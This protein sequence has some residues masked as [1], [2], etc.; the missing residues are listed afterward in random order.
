MSVIHILDPQTANLIAAGEVVD[1][2]ASVVKELLENAIDSGADTITAEIKN[3]GCSLIRITDNGCGMSKEDAA[4]CVKRH[5]TSKLKNPDDLFR[6]ATLGFR[7]EALAAISSVSTFSII[8]KRKQDPIGTKFQVEGDE[9]L[10]YD[11][12]GCPDGTTVLVESL[13]KNQPAR[14]KFLKRDATEASAVLQ[15]VQRI[16]VSHPEISFTF[17]SNGETK[18]QTA[19]NGVLKAAI[20]S[21]YGRE[22]ASSLTPVNGQSEQGIRVSGFITRPDA[23]RANRSCQ[24][25]Y[26]NNRFVKSK[27]MLFALEDAY[28]SYM[29]SDRFPGCVLCLSIDCSRVD[30]NVHPAKLEV[31]F[32]DER[33]VYNAVY[34]AVKNALQGE[35]TPLVYESTAPF[36]NVER[37]VKQTEIKNQQIEFSIAIPKVPPTPPK[38][39][40]LTVSQP[41]LSELKERKEKGDLT[42][43]EVRELEDLLST[44]S[45]PIPRAPFGSSL[46]SEKSF[47]PVC[48]DQAPSAPL[49]SLTFPSKNAENAD[50]YPHNL[51]Q[52][53]LDAPFG[54]EGKVLGVA[55]EAFILY[56]YK[57][58]LFFIDKHAAHERILYEKLKKSH[59]DNSIQLLLSPIAVT[60]SHTEYSAVEENL[61]SLEEIGFLA[62]SFG[63]NKILLRGV[64]LCLSHLNE[65]E[66]TEILTRTAEDLTQ[67]GRT[68]ARK[69]NA[70]DRLLYSL[71]CKAAMKAGIPDNPDNYSALIDQ[72]IEIENIVVCPHG[73]PIITKMTK[74]QL[75]RLF[76]RN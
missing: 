29:K 16:A 74:K 48:K 47:P 58:S 42:P 36:E 13:F 63:S 19:G 20:Y 56:E 31:R 5:A 66:F 49:E 18:L 72:L 25:F 26:I 67:G 6:I 73:R 9:V 21:V 41:D 70:R 76:L 12:I 46:S 45:P 1:R 60:L 8:T 2:P 40:L 71:A 50:V 39:T 35:K 65:E 37:F 23:S 52:T 61:P 34:F 51:P 3:G 33:T 57:D 11:D 22:F 62:E 14:Q 43:K 15:Y 32:S 38:S 24:N 4:L 44:S 30:V 54:R 53:Q 27:T 64:P 75:E 28:K 68:A 69:E 55:F 59:S 17:R 7:G 10:Y